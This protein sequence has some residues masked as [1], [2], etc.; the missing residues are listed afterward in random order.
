MHLGA[1]GGV[2]PGQRISQQDQVQNSTVIASGIASIKLFCNWSNIS[3]NCKITFGCRTTGWAAKIGSRSGRP[4]D[5]DIRGRYSPLD[6]AQVAE[7][8]TD[9]CQLRVVLGSTVKKDTKPRDALRLCQRREGPL[10]VAPPTEVMNSRRR[11]S[12]LHAGPTS[13]LICTYGLAKSKS[14]RARSRKSLGLREFCVPS[15]LGADAQSPSFVVWSS[16][17]MTGHVFL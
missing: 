14:G 5:I 9:C 11:M 1:L 13:V 15:H 7:P 12:D 16:S 8:T 2:A 6:I 17:S 3:A 10:V 4:Y